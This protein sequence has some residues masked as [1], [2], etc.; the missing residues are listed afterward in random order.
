MNPFEMSSSEKIGNKVGNRDRSGEVSDKS[1]DDDCIGC[2]L[3][4]FVL[5][6]CEL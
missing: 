6:E 2:L 5:D 4:N 3:N 1:T